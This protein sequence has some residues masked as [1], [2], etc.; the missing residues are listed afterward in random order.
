MKKNMG[1]TDKS[2]RIVLAVVF[3]IVAFS[4]ALASPWNYV[5]LVFGA[6]F[7][8]TSSIS[9]CPLYVLFG[10]STCKVK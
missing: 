4:G 8:L 3:G 5:L 7:L 10:I 9:F 1:T 2:F 6:I